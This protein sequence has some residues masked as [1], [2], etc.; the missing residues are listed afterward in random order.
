VHRADKPAIALI[1]FDSIARA[2]RTGDAMVK[3]AS[4]EVA[5]AGPVSPGKYLVLITGGEAEV[6][7]SWR[8]GRADGGDAVVDHLFLPG[9]HSDVVEAIHGKTHSLDPDEDSLGVIETR[10]V[11]AAIV[12]CD[13]ACKTAEVRVLEMRLGKG[14]GGKG[15]FTLAGAQWDLEAA[16]ESACASIEERRA[17]LGRELIPRPDA[18]FTGGL[19]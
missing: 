9:V 10:T 6:D 14:I 3:R 5:Y 19:S 18:L 4:V 11:A 17:L 8:E 15:V 12:A 7:E 1:E 13:A 2:Y 16:L